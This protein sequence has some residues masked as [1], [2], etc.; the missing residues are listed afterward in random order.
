LA[1]IP[2]DAVL[3][4]PQ[5]RLRCRGGLLDLLGTMPRPFGP[6]LNTTSFGLETEAELLPRVMNQGTRELGNLRTHPLHLKRPE[7]PRQKRQEDVPLPQSVGQLS[8]KEDGVE[9]TVRVGGDVREHHQPHGLRLRGGIV[10]A[11]DFE[12]NVVRVR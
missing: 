9:L 6:P 8:I 1:A 7:R 2:H 11:P 3:P 5:G 10:L 12:D 4:A